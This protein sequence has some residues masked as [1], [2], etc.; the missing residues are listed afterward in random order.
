MEHIFIDAHKRRDIKT[1]FSTKALGC[2]VEGAGM[3]KSSKKYNFCVEKVDLMNLF[4]SI[5]SFNLNKQRASNSFIN[6]WKFQ[7]IRLTEVIDHTDMLLCTIDN[8]VFERI[9]VEQA[10]NVSFNGFVD[11][12]VK[13]LDG[14]KKDEL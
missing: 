9:K 5:S 3:T 7:Q 2:F 12:L 14:C 13:I 4:V 11:H 10:I 8:E 1:I 6:S